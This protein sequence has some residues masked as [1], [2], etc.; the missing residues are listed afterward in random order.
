[1]CN[2]YMCGFFLCPRSKIRTTPVLALSTFHKERMT[3][4]REIELGSLTLTIDIYLFVSFSFLLY[5]EEEKRKRKK[6]ERKNRFRLHVPS[7]NT[8]TRRGRP[9]NLFI[10]RRKHYR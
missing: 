6:R 7:T 4:C 3:G 9:Y 1:M 2:V 10:L 5:K 8:S